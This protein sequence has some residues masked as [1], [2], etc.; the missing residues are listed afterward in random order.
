ME[1]SRRCWRA[2]Q[3]APTPQEDSTGCGEGAMGL[4]EGQVAVSWEARPA[5]RSLGPARLVFQLMK[6]VSE[7]C[8]NITRVYNIGKSRQGLKLYA[9][10]L[11][12][13]PGEHEVG[14]VPLGST[15]LWAQPSRRAEPAA[16]FPLSPHLGL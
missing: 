6:V 8:P 11:S 14:E 2:E 10:E 15:W 13:R 7:M 5:M 16:P 9:V 3:K 4:W 1:S 12:D